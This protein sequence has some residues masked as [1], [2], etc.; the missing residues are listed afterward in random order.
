M[1]NKT[2]VQYINVQYF[3]SGDGICTI[4][5]LTS[6]IPYDK[7]KEWIFND[8]QIKP[9]EQYLDNL[10]VTRGYCGFEFT[11]IGKAILEVGDTE[12]E[13]YAKQIALTKAQA[14]AFGKAN[15][16]Y[17]MVGENLRAHLENIETFM[18]G[19]Y[20]SYISCTKHVDDLID[21]GYEQ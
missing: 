12:N 16:I 20:N 13:T 1:K 18:T 19:T 3:K 15:R 2:G 7:I 11:T 4:C 8:N 17:G 9:S 14:K 6:M 21:S 10:G 5:K